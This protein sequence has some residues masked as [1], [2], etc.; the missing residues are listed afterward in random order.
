MVREMDFRRKQQDSNTSFRNL[1]D[2]QD[3]I[4]EVETEKMGHVVREY[5][6]SS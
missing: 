3:A 4:P 1:F 5:L 2:S 6:L